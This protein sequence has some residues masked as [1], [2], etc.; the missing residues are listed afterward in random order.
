M[1]DPRSLALEFGREARRIRRERDL[2]QEVVCSRSGLGAKHISEIERGRR[3]PRLSTIA[4]L[5]RGLGVNPSEL[6][7]CFDDQTS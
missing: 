4:K 5:A 3:E 2:S 6:L 1:I 7:R